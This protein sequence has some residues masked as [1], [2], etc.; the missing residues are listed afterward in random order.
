MSS[1]GL[2]AQY[3]D[4]RLPEAKALSFAT[5]ELEHPVVQRGGSFHTSVADFSRCVLQWHRDQEYW[6][7][8]VEDS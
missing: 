8:Y 4:Q 1:F 7:S 2:L 6:V 5:A 3:S